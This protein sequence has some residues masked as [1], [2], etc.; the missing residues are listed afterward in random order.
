MR[1]NSATA[2]GGM[3]SSS[4]GLGQNPPE[5]PQLPPPPEP[6]DSGDGPHDVGGGNRTPPAVEPL[7]VAGVIVPRVPAVPS[8]ADRAPYIKMYT[9]PQLLKR[10]VPPNAKIILDI[11]GC[12]WRAKHDGVVLPSIGF[13]PHCLHNRRTSLEEL[14]TIL[15]SHHPGPRPAEAHVNA[16]S[17]A[18][19]DGLLDDRIEK[20][21]Q[22]RT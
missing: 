2:D 22:R 17:E 19:W 4:N 7:P 11:P 14:L 5:A 3:H 16:I 13:G 9:T 6:C 1:P 21:R 20:P 10:I 8:G 18:E 12:R 15:W